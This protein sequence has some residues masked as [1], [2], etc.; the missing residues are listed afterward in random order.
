MDVFLTT[1]VKASLAALNA[2][3][4]MRGATRMSWSRYQQFNNCQASWFLNSFNITTR[5]VQSLPN[6]HISFDGKLIQKVIEVAY[7][8]GA[9]ANRLHQ[10]IAA[11]TLPEYINRVVSLMDACLI[12]PPREARLL[13]IGNLYDW[14]KTPAAQDY[15]EQ[16]LK[17][18]F[19]GEPVD[20][21]L[22]EFIIHR[23]AI[24]I[25]DR[26][27]VEL[28][29]GKSYKTMLRDIVKAT[30]KAVEYFFKHLAFNRTSVEMWVFAQVEGIEFCG[31]ADMAVNTV[32]T[33]KK[34][35]AMWDL[36]DQYY[37]IDGKRKVQS[38]QTHEQ[39]EFYSTLIALKQSIRP[40]SLVLFDYTEGQ[41]HASAFNPKYLDTIRQTAGQF[42]QALPKLQ[43]NLKDSGLEVKEPW[44]LLP[45][46]PSD[47]ACR[48][49]VAGDEG[50][51]ELSKKRRLNDRMEYSLNARATDALVE[52][53]LGIDESGYSKAGEISL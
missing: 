20:P 18:A 15:L 19:N 37:L 9:V 36:R 22:R 46:S 27:A 21:Y 16:K 3:N 24:C 12:L 6:D 50:A 47:N 39:L 35:D 13:E 41:A 49:C 52:Q 25:V 44:K 29:R 5:P 26:D 30:I 32:D 38:Y 51:C 17:E 14:L 4:K 42:H 11:G 53:Q 2:T 8:N 40:F 7:K 10:E 34:P 43:A 48:F 33:T 23:P 31:M 28:E 45:R 1:D